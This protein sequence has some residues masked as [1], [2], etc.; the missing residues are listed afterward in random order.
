VVSGNLRNPSKLPLSVEYLQGIHGLNLN[1]I[2]NILTIFNL[3]IMQQKTDQ[4]GN[5][6]HMINFVWPIQ[7]PCINGI[8]C[9]YR[10]FSARDQQPEDA[11]SVHRFELKNGEH[12]N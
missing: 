5:Q 2:N 9:W 11:I 12:A 6:K 4:A 1:K 3:L 7:V 10:V 8:H